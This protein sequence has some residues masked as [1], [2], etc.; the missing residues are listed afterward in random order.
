MYLI[1][2]ELLLASSKYMCTYS[3]CVFGGNLMRFSSAISL[4]LQLNE[5]PKF[6]FDKSVPS[7]L[8]V[9]K[10]ELFT[11]SLNMEQFPETNAITVEKTN[12]KNTEDI[13]NLSCLRFV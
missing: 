1:Q 11:R 9:V 7:H 6:P 12:A 3:E 2:K 8:Q 10:N 13:F 4:I 5:Y